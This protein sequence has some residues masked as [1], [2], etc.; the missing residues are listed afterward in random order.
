[1]ETELCIA[2]SMLCLKNLQA[3]FEQ[4]L[5]NSL[6]IKNVLQAIYYASTYRSKHI[7]LYCFKWIL[8]HLVSSSLSI[9]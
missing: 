1:M 5:I 2:A 6:C 7:L 4:Q 9:H 8:M 3:I